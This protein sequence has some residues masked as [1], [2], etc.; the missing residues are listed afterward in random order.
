MIFDVN[1]ESFLTGIVEGCDCDCGCNDDDDKKKKKKNDD[2]DTKDKKDKS[3]DDDSDKKDDSDDDDDFDDDIKEES[4]GSK[5]S[6]KEGCTS[7]KSVDEGCGSGKKTAEDESCKTGFKK[8]DPVNEAYSVIIEGLFSNN[9]DT[10]DQMADK[11]ETKLTAINNPYAKDF[12]KPDVSAAGV[13]KQSRIKQMISAV[14]NIIEKKKRQAELGQRYPLVLQIQREV[15]ELYKEIGKIIAD[16]G[17]LSTDY[18][19]EYGTSIPYKDIGIKDKKSGKPYKYTMFANQ[20]PFDQIYDICMNI[21]H[22]ANPVDTIKSFKKNVFDFLYNNY[23]FIFECTPE[24]RFAAEETVSFTEHIMMLRDDTD[25][26]YKMLYNLTAYLS[27]NTQFIAF[28]QKTYGE[29]AKVYESRAKDAAPTMDEIYAECLRYSAGIVDFNF[30][31]H[32]LLFNLMVQYR[33]QMK[34][35]YKKITDATHM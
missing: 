22:C 14:A 19:N 24:I 1:M 12:A 35:I 4:C 32:E 11:I 18:A 29:V 20:I 5:K 3:D 15:M 31:A 2:E 25:Q 30:K 13:Q 21:A 16:N 9:G 7:K 28:F 23:W 6:V 33:D 26:I 34:E 10:V 17:P 8:K 27:Q